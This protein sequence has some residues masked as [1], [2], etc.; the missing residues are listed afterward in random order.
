MEV[1]DLLQLVGTERLA[2]LTGRGRAKHD[3]NILGTV[4]EVG[5]LKQSNGRDGEH[6]QNIIKTSGTRNN[7]LVI[8]ICT[9]ADW[10]SPHTKI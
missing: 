3:L 7:T 8:V 9:D 10:A 1:M 4:S 6:F 2:I 5:N